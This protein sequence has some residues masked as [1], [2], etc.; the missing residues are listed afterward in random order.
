[1]SSDGKQQ[2]SNEDRK[3]GK[4]TRIS[5][6]DFGRES[7]V[8]EEMGVGM[9]PL[10]EIPTNVLMDKRARLDGDAHSPGLLMAQQFRSTETVGQSC[11]EQ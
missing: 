9:M 2:G 10:K 7:V 4:W 1:M 5:R 3:A 8:E 11:R 6:G